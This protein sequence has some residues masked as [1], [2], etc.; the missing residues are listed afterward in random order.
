MITT[1][2]AKLVE[3]C[4]GSRWFHLN[5][6]IRRNCYEQMESTAGVTGSGIRDEQQ[7]TINI[8]ETQSGF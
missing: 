2:E 3:V 8:Q 1:A 5:K 7:G 6:Y 4:S